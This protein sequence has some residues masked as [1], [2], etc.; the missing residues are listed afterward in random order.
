MRTRSIIGTVVVILIVASACYYFYGYRSQ[1][2]S[3]NFNAMMDNTSGAATTTAVKTALALNSNVASYD[4]HVETNNND[5]TLSGQVPTVEDK[6]VA[7]EVASSTKGVANVVNNL[8]VDP[9]MLAA[10]A[11]KQYIT[12]LEIKASMLQSILNSSDLKTQQLKVEVNNGEVRLSGSVQTAAQ[13]T[14]A[15]A[16][17]QAITNVRK[18]DATTLVVTQL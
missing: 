3:A 17:A 14:A 10:T 6:R 5:V 13:K 4:I 1:G 18:V 15:E 9:K 8:L 11:A 2:I 16:T 7:E 12:D